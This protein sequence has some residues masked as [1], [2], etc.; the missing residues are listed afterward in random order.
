MSLFAQGQVWMTAITKYSRAFYAGRAASQVPAARRLLHEVLKLLQPESVIDVGCG[1]G[2]LLSVLPEFGISDF[3]GLEG[4]WI[5]DDQLQVAPERV[6]RHDLNQ[7]FACGRRFELAVSIEVAEHLEPGR[8]E[9]FVDD[10]TRLA[11]VVLF[12]AA[13]PGQGG[14]NHINERWQ[15]YWAG[16]FEKRGYC[17][18]DH[19]RPALWTDPE[20]PV[21]WRQNVLLYANQ[22]GLERSPRLA[23]AQQASINRILDLAHPR[24]FWRLAKPRG[25]S[26]ILRKQL[27]RATRHTLARAF[28]HAHERQ[29]DGPA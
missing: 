29:Y 15:S 20:V 7:T 4:P 11:D 9:E 27:P 19:L 21:S 22:R 23:D 25:L 16:L 10:L 18:I 6:S 1:D 24:A 8:G 2:S 26:H 5:G 12:S 3:C 13:I 28:G 14:V 17:V